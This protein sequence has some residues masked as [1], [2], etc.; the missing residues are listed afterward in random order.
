MTI[1]NTVKY[2][3]LSDHSRNKFETGLA[4]GPNNIPEILT[5]QA[6]TRPRFKS[7]PGPRPYHRG[8]RIQSTQ[9][10]NPL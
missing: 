7:S 3:T 2:S 10:L 1:P 6:A 8:T 9:E 4:K 5:K